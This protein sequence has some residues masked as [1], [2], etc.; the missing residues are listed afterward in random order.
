MSRGAEGSSGEKRD[1]SIRYPDFYEPPAEQ[2]I[3]GRRERRPGRPFSGPFLRGPVELAWIQAAA[4]KGGLAPLATGMALWQLAG[5]RK[6]RV[7]RASNWKL[8]KIANVSV[9]R[10]RR[11]LEVLEDAGLIVRTFADGET[12]KGRTIKLNQ[13]NPCR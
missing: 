4:E 1:F 2:E 5:Y 12:L 8:A 13:V 9:S 3:V 11:G 7:V 10:V 6:E